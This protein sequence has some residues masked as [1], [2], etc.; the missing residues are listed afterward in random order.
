MLYISSKT[1]IAMCGSSLCLPDRWKVGLLRKLRFHQPK[2]GCFPRIR[3]AN[4]CRL[5]DVLLLKIGRWCF[6]SRGKNKKTQTRDFSVESGEPGDSGRF[7]VGGFGRHL[8]EMFTPFRSHK[9][10]MESH[11]EDQRR[12][13]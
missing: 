9:R 2:L 11:M 7:Q 13:G 12:R 3:G 10:I 6:F 4:M 1:K 5:I 8:M